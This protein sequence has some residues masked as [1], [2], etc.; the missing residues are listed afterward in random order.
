GRLDRRA[1]DA[2]PDALAADLHGPAGAHGL[3]D[4]ALLARARRSAGIDLRHDPAGLCAVLGAG[5][6]E[7]SAPDHGP[8]VG[9]LVEIRR[10]LVEGLREVAVREVAV[11]H[12]VLAAVLDHRL[13]AAESSLRER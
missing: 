12:S 13:R 3:R 4:L 9:V 5:R 8:A 7:L 6:A 11:Q 10:Q 1:A 2:G